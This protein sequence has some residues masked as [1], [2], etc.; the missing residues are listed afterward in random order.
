MIALCLGGALSVWAEYEAAK[1]L[2]GDRP[3]L[4]VACN[5]AAVRFPGHLDAFASLHP[6]LVDGWLADRAAAGHNV[7]CR[8]FTHR[9][10][11][12]QNA[13]AL[14]WRWFGSSGLYTAQVAI[15]RLDCAGAILCGVPMDDNAGHIHHGTWDAAYHY[16]AG[17][18]DA[19]AQKPQVRSM[20]GYTQELFGAP[21]IPW[22]ESLDLRDAA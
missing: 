12:R 20:S 2:I 15:D 22:L 4:T 21:D 19:A 1:T 7:D 16:R 13:E 11:R 10:G 5:H 8:I 18:Q 17:L 3:F 14:A 9:P 6:E